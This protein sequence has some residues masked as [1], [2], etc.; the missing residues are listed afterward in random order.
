MG[1]NLRKIH[2]TKY[3]E[4][5]R[6]KTIADV[7]QNV[8]GVCTKKLHMVI[9]CFNTQ[10]FFSHNPKISREEKEIFAVDETGS[11]NLLSAIKLI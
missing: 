4:Q 8:Q 6:K 9:N 2:C 5:Q 10:N 7:V 11:T 1:R 3:I